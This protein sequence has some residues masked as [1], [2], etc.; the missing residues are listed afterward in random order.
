MLETEETKATQKTHSEMS[1]LS[2]SDSD[3]SL[4]VS[5]VGSNELLDDLVCKESVR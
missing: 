5:D 2:L 1:D 4:S 3:M